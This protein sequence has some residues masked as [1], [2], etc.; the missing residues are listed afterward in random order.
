[1]Q[2]SPKSPSKAQFF[3]SRHTPLQWLN[4]AQRLRH[5]G[6]LLF[7]AYLRDSR[8][9]PSDD[10]PEGLDNLDMD[11]PAA[12]LFG[13]S[14]ENLVKAIRLR[15]RLDQQPDGEIKF[16]GN[17]HQMKKLLDGIQFR[18]TPDEADLVQRLEQFVIWSGKY[19]VPKSESAV[20]LQQNGK[21]SE[22]PPLAIA[23][24]EK[25]IFDQLFDKL[26]TT[27]GPLFVTEGSIIKFID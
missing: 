6:E 24:W 17:G 15:K 14:I 1:M 4:S 23:P 8:K 2:S 26:E 27:L 5:A 25:E 11:G 18:P 3:K 20:F 9:S 16:P 7:N 19:P 21:S 13:L 22:L 10:P 12:L